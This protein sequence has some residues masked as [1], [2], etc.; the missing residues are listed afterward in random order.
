MRVMFT[1]CPMSGHFLPMVP[2]ARQIQAEDHD[3]VFCVSDDL[4]STVASSGF[5]VV[6]VGGLTREWMASE[7]NRRGP[8]RTTLAR[9]DKWRH[10]TST[11]AY[12]AEAFVEPL[13]DI[14]DQWQPDV[15]VHEPA[16]FAAAIA[17][18]VRGLPHVTHSW[19]ALRESQWGE[20][21]AE[22]MAPVWGR[23]GLVPLL[24]G[25]DYEYLYFDICPPSL[26]SPALNGI[27]TARPLR[28]DAPG[29]A[30]R[31]PDWLAGLPKDRTLYVTMGTLPVFNTEMTLLRMVVEGLA[32][33]DVNVIVTVG[34][35]NDPEE[36]G[37]QPPNVRVER[38]VPQ[39]DVL[40]F[41][42]GVICHGGSGTMFGALR[43]GIPLLM[44]PL[45]AD[46]FQNAD[47]CTKAGVGRAVDVE[48]LTTDLVTSEA[49]VLLDDTSYRYRSEAV[50]DEIRAMPGPEFGVRHLAVL[51]CS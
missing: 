16:E 2:L 7:G 18:T 1:S 11:F 29:P 44:I 51:V 9:T 14:V 46:Q 3:L 22:L 10:G 39:E 33:H 50:R 31:P 12:R 47:A 4:A 24:H 38:Y 13:I 23:F 35:N 15:I 28:P 17:A 42:T 6:V 5:P 27:P 21:R 30:T 25:G 45:G 34:N 49:A 26:R 40:P 37:P 43:Q 19:G 8:A 36:L 20:L 41:V 48:T 32:R